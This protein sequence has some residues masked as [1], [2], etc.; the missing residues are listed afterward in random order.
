[1]QGLFQWKLYYASNSKSLGCFESIV[2]TA[3]IIE[4]FSYVALSKT[5]ISLF[6]A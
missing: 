5:L 4:K 2:N 6:H 1:M 3:Y